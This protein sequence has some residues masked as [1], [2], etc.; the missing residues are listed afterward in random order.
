MKE[1]V[2][3][4]L[5]GILLGSIISTGAIYFYTIAENN[6][7]SNQQI[8]NNDFENRGDRGPRNDMENP[9][10]MPNNNQGQQ[11]N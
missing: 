8:Q 2:I 10:E 6:S 9:P 7:N 5:I 3:I 1:K 11:S 4:F